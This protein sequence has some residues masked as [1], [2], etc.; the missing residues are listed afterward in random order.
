[1]R[2]KTVPSGRIGHIVRRDLT[3]CEKSWKGIKDI[4]GFGS[5]QTV[6]LNME[7]GLKVFTIPSEFMKII[8]Q[9]PKHNY[10]LAE[11]EVHDLADKSGVQ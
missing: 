6:Q 9:L 2:S 3:A 8:T 10:R 1:M 5:C 4:F 11:A 7:F